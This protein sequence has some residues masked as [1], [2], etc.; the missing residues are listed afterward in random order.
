MEQS[1]EVVYKIFIHDMLEA[2]VKYCNNTK[3]M[4]VHK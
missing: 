2:L 1:T 3:Y 4:L